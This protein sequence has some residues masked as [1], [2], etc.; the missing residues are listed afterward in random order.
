MITPSESFT[1]RYGDAKTFD[2]VPDS[3]YRIKSVM[4][5]DVD[6]TDDVVDNEMSIEKSTDKSKSTDKVENPN[7]YDSVLFYVGFLLISVMGMTGIKVYDY[8]TR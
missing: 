1:I 5:N 8:K 3:G 2:I 6:K 7:T 4:V